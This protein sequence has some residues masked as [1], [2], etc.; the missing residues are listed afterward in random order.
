MR[1]ALLAPQFAYPKTG[2]VGP[3]A[4]K[5]AEALAALGD[6]V[7]IVSEGPVVPQSGAITVR[8]VGARWDLRAALRAL[9]LLRRFGAGVLL[10][11]YT[12]FNFNPRSL[13]PMFIAAL[14]RASGLRVGTYVHE[15]FYQE[16]S[17]AVKSGLKARVLALR[18]ALMLA[19]TECIFVASD[20][21]RN[22]LLSIAPFVGSKSVYVLPIGANIEPGPGGTWRADRAD[23]TVI[24]S[25]GVVMPRR[26]FEIIIGA[27]A[28]LVA[29]GRDVH[30]RLVGNVFDRAY[31]E[32][33][34]SVA[35]ACGVLQRVTLTGALEDIDV[36]DEFRKAYVYAYALEDGIIA[37][38]GSLLAA[39]A[40]GIPIVATRSLSDEAD[41]AACTLQA[42]GEDGFAEA[43]A[44]ILDDPGRR[45]T[46]SSDGRALYEERFEWE[47]IAAR[48]RKC[49]DEAS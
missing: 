47:T 8:S 16:G 48:M 6:E 18:D 38:S 28:R 31:A 20:S 42:S 22:R 46:L 35:E 39:F 9:G 49:F 12:P 15:I 40:H 26:R 14:S 23:P 4:R 33:C 1:I 2:G 45:G 36:S 24:M 27:L 30:L 19:C 25:F 11:E 10:I 32:Q 43:I 3:H 13:A 44:T 34:L 21:K 7:L 17:A 5:L 29:R 41:L 37:S